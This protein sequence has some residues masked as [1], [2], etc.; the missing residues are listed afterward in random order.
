MKTNSKEKEIG[1]TDKEDEGMFFT[2]DDLCTECMEVLRNKHHAFTIAL[3]KYK[4]SPELEIDN[5]YRGISAELT[6]RLFRQAYEELRRRSPFAQLV[7]YPNE[8][9]W[10]NG[11]LMPSLM[12]R[13][14]K[15]FWVEKNGGKENI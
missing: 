8:S 11:N 14:V 7:A 1:F 5:R 2:D 12:N 9:W 15:E 13:T 10:R 3:W 6:E 4:G